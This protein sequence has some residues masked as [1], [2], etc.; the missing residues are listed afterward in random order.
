M[1]KLTVVIGNVVWDVDL[2][3]APLLP[4]AASGG[5]GVRVSF[6]LRLDGDVSSDQGGLVKVRGCKVGTGFGLTDTQDMTN[7]MGLMKDY[8]MNQRLM[9]RSATFST[10]SV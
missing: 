5:A 9:C 4:E 6:S 2:P 7:T 8:F 10:S 1:L 3:V